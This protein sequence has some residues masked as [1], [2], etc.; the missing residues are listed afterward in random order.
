[1]G[2]VLFMVMWIIWTWA[3]A[4]GLRKYLELGAADAPFPMW[5]YALIAVPAFIPACLIFVLLIPLEALLT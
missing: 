3:L 5:I 4:A 2:F 1:M